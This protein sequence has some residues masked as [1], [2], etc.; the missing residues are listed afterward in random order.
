[1]NISSTTFPSISKGQQASES[2]SLGS[3]KS[4][5]TE[6][7]PQDTMTLGGGYRPGRKDDVFDS[8]GETAGTLFFAGIGASGAV[9]ATAVAARALGLGSIPGP[10]V[11][12]V[13]L[14]GAIGGGAGYLNGHGDLMGKGV[15][16]LSSIGVGAAIGGMCGGTTGALVGGTLG[17]TYAGVALC[18]SD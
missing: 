3:T 7:E 2:L 5:Q 1:M 18:M 14:A 9:A 11:A 16:S 4:D 6:S 17:T 8:I 10:A 12:V 15:I 13:A